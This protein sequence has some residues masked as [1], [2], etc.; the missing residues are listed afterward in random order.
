MLPVVKLKRHRQQNRI[1]DAET[2]LSENPGFSRFDTSCLRLHPA[3]T[4]L[5][6]FPYNYSCIFRPSS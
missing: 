2:R 3:F 5:I 6:D 4:Y 1:Y